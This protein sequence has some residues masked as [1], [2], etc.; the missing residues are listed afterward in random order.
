LS[1]GGLTSVQFLLASGLALIFFV[2]LANVVIVQYAKGSL[3]SALDQGVRTGAVTRSIGD[4]EERVSAVLDGLLS[5]SIGDT[6][7]FEC[8]V[9]GLAMAASASLTVESWTPFTGDFPV[10]IEAAATLEPD[11]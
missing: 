7:R 3:R 4:C 6:I 10:Q 11:V 9:D 5:G 1:E 2:A 8:R